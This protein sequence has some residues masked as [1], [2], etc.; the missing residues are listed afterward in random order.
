MMKKSA[1]S[2]RKKSGSGEEREETD[3]VREV[4]SAQICSNYG[5]F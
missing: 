1:N 5:N 4:I 2:L 3:T